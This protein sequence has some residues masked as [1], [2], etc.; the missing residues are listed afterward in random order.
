MADNNS[1]SAELDHD[2]DAVL[3]QWGD[4]TRETESEAASSAEACKGFWMRAVAWVIDLI[5][6]Y[7]AMAAI[8]YLVATAVWL[9]LAYSGRTVFVDEEPGRCQTY[10]LL[11]VHMTLYFAIFEWLY[12]AT[13]GKLVLG[14][15]VIMLD[16]SPCTARAALIRGLYRLIDGLFFGIPAQQ[17]MKTPLF[18]RLGDR[19]AKTVVAAAGDSA[20]RQPRPWWRF[21]V[22]AALNLSLFGLFSVATIMLM[23]R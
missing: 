14:M 16:G 6:Y 3:D 7:G 9:L 13:A 23:I 2:L 4:L 21:L 1:P 12:G 8:N 10:I 15:R 11:L 18:Q 19:Q 20:I 17:S 5:I 22:A